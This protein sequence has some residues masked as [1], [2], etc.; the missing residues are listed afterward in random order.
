MSSL[1]LFPSLIQEFFSVFSFKLSQSDGQVLRQPCPSC[2]LWRALQQAESHSRSHVLTAVLPGSVRGPE[3]A[4]RS[5]PAPYPAL[6]RPQLLV[7]WELIDVRFY[8]AV[9]PAGRLS[10]FTGGRSGID[11]DTYRVNEE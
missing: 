10:A 4:A 2:S 9:C 8:N 7:Q 3:H 11:T 1:T 6:P 5:V